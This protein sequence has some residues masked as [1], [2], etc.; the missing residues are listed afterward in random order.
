[1]IAPAAPAAKPKL[2]VE[3]KLIS[4]Q[5]YEET[6]KKIKSLIIERKGK[7]VSIKPKLVFEI[8]YEEI[9]K[10]PTYE[11]GFALRFP[12]FIRDRSEDKSPEDA[13]TI[14]RVKYL[15]KTQGKAG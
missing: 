6:T 7:A 15:F 10:S 11:S 5:E 12:R 2:L 4:E 14:E 1:M 8:G 3:E 13:D 9:Q